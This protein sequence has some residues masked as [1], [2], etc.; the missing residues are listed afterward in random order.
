M[1]KRSSLLHLCG[2]GAVAALAAV[3]RSG[4]L[5][6]YFLNTFFVLCLY[7]ILSQSWNILGGY[8]GQVNLGQAAFFGTGALVCR[9]LWTAGHSIGLAL[10]GGAVASLVVACVI[11]TAALRLRA[12][13][14]AIGTLGLAM[15]AL[16]TIQTLLP[17]TDF[18]PSDLLSGYDAVARCYLALAAAAAT[19]ELV[20]VLAHSKLGLAM[21]CVRED[22]DAALAVGI[23]VV[24]HKLIA[25][26]LSTF[27][28]GLA[29]G[30]FAYYNVSMYYYV[31][32]ELAW[33][34]DPLLIVFIGGTGTVFGPVLGA[35]CYVLLKELFALSLGQVN[36]LIFGVAFILIVL[37]LP[38]GL[39]SFVSR[40]RRPQSFALSP[41][42]RPL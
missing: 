30:L 17:G 42:K 37:F 15:I 36:V 35:L 11:G 22:E 27:I 8:C 20:Y 1:S 32:F 14:F 16:V 34:F 2:W 40:V 13:Y 4:H 28:A 7:V 18:L 12:H 23:N 6:E 29:G 9:Y 31:P 21:L 38:K 39:I 25:T 3:L 26:A 10:L 19:T 24:K 5:G 33:S 41:A